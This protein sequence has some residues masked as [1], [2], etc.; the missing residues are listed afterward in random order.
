MNGLPAPDED[1]LR[2]LPL[3]LAQLYR[4]AHNAKNP[5][6]CCLAAYYLWE[7]G[8]KLLA[9]VAVAVYAERDEP[10]AGLAESLQ[11][12]ARPSLGHWWEFLRRL[13]PVL[14]DAGDPPFAAVRDLVLG[15]SRDDLPRAAGL[16]AALLEAVDGHAS[17]RSTVRVSELFDRLVRYRNRE[18]GHG[19][20]GQRPASFYD[21]L[22]RA[23][24]L[25]VPEVLERLD[26]LVGR[27]LI[28]IPEVR[29]QADGTWLVERYELIGESARRIAS[30]ERRGGDGASL[31]RPECLY[32]QAAGADPADD[33]TVTL[34]ALHP[35]LV[36]DP[37]TNEVLFLNARRGRR[38]TEYVCYS[39]GRVLERNDL[40]GERRALLARV[41]GMAVDDTAVEGWAARS[42]AEEPAAA[43]DPS[44]PPR[45]LGE[46]ELLSE[47]GRGGMGVVYRAWQPS[48][49]RQ[50]ALK[51]LFHTGDA[52]AEARFGREIRA[53]ARA[54]HPH[55]VKIF[56]SASE[57][58]H[59]FYAME[60]VEGTTL[61]AVCERLQADKAAAAALDWPTWQATLSTVCEES[62]RQ[63][64]SLTDDG[65]G[66]PPPP[67]A[68]PTRAPVLS[69]DA[70]AMG[71]GYVQHVVELVRQAAE[72]A[73]ALHEVGVIHRDIKPG[74]IMVSAD[75]S[76]AVL[77]DLG[78][79][80]LAD[81]I[82]GR[83]T[84]TRQ[85]V[86]TLRYASPEQV[87]AVGQ[88]DR[89]SDVY[90]L[91]VALWE[92]LTLRPMFGAG[93]HTPTPA[94]MERI[95]YEEP[96][97][98]R[99]YNPAVPRDLDAIILRCLQ[100]SRERRYSTARELADDLHRFLKGETVQARPVS[101]AVRFGRWCKRHPVQV[102]L[103][104]LGV[105]LLGA[106]AVAGYADLE[107][108][109]LAQIRKEKER[110]DKFQAE[111][112]L[113]DGA[114]LGDQGDA[115]RGMLWMARSLAVCPGSAPEVE[116]A[117][118]T[119]LPSAAATIHT[120]E[121]VYS[122]AGQTVVTA[123]SPDGKT[124]LLG[125]G[126]GTS[127]I[128]VATGSTR[129]KLAAPAR[130]VAAGAFSPDG[131]LV[132]IATYGGEIR[133]ADASTGEDAGP[134]ITQKGVPKWVVF[135]PD[136]KTVLVAAQ[137]G[138][139]LREY[140]VGTR[141][142]VGP[143][144]ACKDN[145]YV[146]TY[147]P[148]GRRVATAAKE[149]R[150]CVWDAA[151]GQLVGEPMVHPG[152]AFTVA[153]S[154]DGKTLATGCLDGG[155]RFW[156]AETGKPL[157]GTLYHRGAVRSA[158]FSRDGRLLLTSSEDGT[159]RLWEVATGR[160]VGQM[161]AHPSELRYALFSPDQTHIVTSGYE[162]TARL[163]R[164]AREDAVA[165]VLHHDGAVAE[166]AVS[167]DGKQVLT[168]CRES[169]DRPGESRLW[170]LATAAPLGPP[171][172]QQ[173]Q[174]MAVAFSPDGKRVLTGGNDG[175]AR[176]WNSADSS[177]AQ[178]PWKYDG[179][180]VAAVAFSPDGRLAAF[181]GRGR[182]I[183]LREVAGGKTVATWQV[184]DHESWVWGLAF[185]PDGRTL[186]MGSGDLAARLWSVPDGTPVGQPMKHDADA[187]TALV[188]PDGQVILTCSHDKTARL[189]SA[190][191]GQPLSPP[192]VHRGEVRAG[193]FRPDGKA[194]ATASAD[195]TARLWAVPGG[196]SLALP[197]F[198]DGWVRSVAFSPDGKLLATGC[199]DG[200]A[201]LW[202]AETGTALGAVLRHRG[203]VNRIAFSP[204][205][206]T[207]LTAS[208]DG[209]A[210]LWTPPPP[211]GGKPD[212]VA[213]WVQVLTGMELDEEGT[214]QVLPGDA[215]EQRRRQLEERGG[216]PPATFGALHGP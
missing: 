165:R 145:L 133:F 7:A 95:Q 40:A 45:Q 172:S 208:S 148:D 203:P 65:A 48:L 66:G 147:S 75:G 204:D 178:E 146:A 206:K 173:G 27:R 56:T 177:P 131:N 69:R 52:K 19:A 11:N 44:R 29:R 92:L 124:L 216:V 31:P 152:V 91:G 37:E 43:P 207:V 138:E 155:I 161:L 59:W 188:S 162:G 184:Y 10:E 17:A 24:L 36:Y 132:V 63:E 110:A 103:A 213:L 105:V 55:L 112:L 60:L 175:Y 102:I 96:E 53:L 78:L 71:R 127:L 50:V 39:T 210:R 35:L 157:P 121:A 125:G 47:L 6:D 176:L 77:M 120:L 134:S 212:H 190:H 193:A 192:L 130:E 198:H 214:A 106:A 159:A 70:P 167:P 1:L 23:L 141:E 164:L 158:V 129:C 107:A 194:V 100:K 49:G 139:A 104:V 111:L 4:R 73:H 136:G 41:L 99:R 122:H 156:E 25:G 32:L 137:F 8:L 61:A 117:I 9:S 21:R 33:E 84:R 86:G 153:F 189:W 174:V 149:N 196:D 187:R 54:E 143:T 168:G 170:D 215:W 80:Q 179:N 144:F 38:R 163:W 183:Q 12:L 93:E 72:A 34:V 97:G 195:G 26:V 123:F 101:R 169:K 118:R 89:R 201:R 85:F 209:T 150:A 90:S 119:A 202:D 22:G 15:R 160:P 211:V 64:K 81:D 82:Q 199:D 98:P 42:Q 2:R 109:Y 116:R 3:P 185:T 140:D 171:M 46:F 28:Y 67:P 76:Q 114:A 135:R 205:G 58:D 83:L 16:D 142:P 14:A 113:K 191:D 87:L 151:T 94:L 18:V 51:K 79:A 30:L 20:A 128:D 197:L 13:T 182:T 154:P 166:I 57:G 180:V 186:A 88:L 108:G 74:N 200:T 115:G 126:K 62:R 181:G 68:P 5:L